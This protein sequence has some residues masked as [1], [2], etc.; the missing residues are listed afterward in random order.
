MA[1]ATPPSA[2]TT[3]DLEACQERMEVNLSVFV[4]ERLHAAEQ[5]LLAALGRQ[6][7]LFLVAVAL[8]VALLAVVV[9]A[10]PAR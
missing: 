5:R 7:R 8:A 3:A 10:A 9:L 1:D 4:D 2:A 6:T